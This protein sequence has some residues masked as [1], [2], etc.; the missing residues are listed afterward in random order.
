MNPLFNF[1]VF[2]AAS[3]LALL[4]PGPAQAQAP[5]S[6]IGVVVMHGKGGS[7]DKHVNTLAQALRGLMRTPSRILSSG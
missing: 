7:P 6:A 1:A 4:L 5:A 2:A 3:V